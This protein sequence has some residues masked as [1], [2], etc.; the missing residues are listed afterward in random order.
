MWLDRYDHIVF[1]IMF[2]RFKS[3]YINRNIIRSSALRMASEL[4]SPCDCKHAYRY[5][6]SN[7][8]NNEALATILIPSAAT[9]RF[10]LAY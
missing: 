9:Y 1:S 2:V 10:N 3:K 4:N 5:I 8:D 6:V 7:K